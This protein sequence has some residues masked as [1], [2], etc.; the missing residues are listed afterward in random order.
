MPPEIH[1]AVAGVYSLVGGIGIIFMSYI[2][3]VL[4]GKYPYK[5][6]AKLSLNVELD[7]WF[8]GA[9]FVLASIVAS[10]IFFYAVYIKAKERCT[11]VTEEP[12]ESKET[13]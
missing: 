13:F 7:F 12:R 11:T 1:G 10:L 3:G 9:P 6:Q 4:F 2:G 8:E 5:V